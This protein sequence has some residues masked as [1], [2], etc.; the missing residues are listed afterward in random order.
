MYS[1]VI[2]HG[3][4]PA[5][6]RQ[7]FRAA[8]L[9]AALNVLRVAVQGEG[10]LKTMPNNTAIMI[11]FAACF[12]LH[13]STTA[14]AG[15]DSTLAPSI[16]TLIAETTETLERIGSTPVQR[17][18]LSCLFARQL[19]HILKLAARSS[20]D[21][22]R[23]PE[24]AASSSTVAT[25]RESDVLP[26]NIKTDM[27]G[28]VPIT[29]NNGAAAGPAMDMAAAAANGG[30]SMPPDYLMFSTMSNNELDEVIINTDVGM[31]TLWDD[32]QFHNSDL[33]WMDWK[34]FA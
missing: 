8:G 24:M 17:K 7:F 27:G 16:R 11:S 22:S 12:A 33:D 23:H 3:T 2:N 28:G 18:G 14:D 6:A 34:T 20:S 13:I 31:E 15:R 1:S 26:A 25:A 32:F 9:S 10:Q 29:G 5:A 30:P 21:H 4:A 19:K